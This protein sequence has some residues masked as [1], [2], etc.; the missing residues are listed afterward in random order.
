[1]KRQFLFPILAVV[2]LL[3]A[4][5][6]KAPDPTTPLT[7]DPVT[8]AITWIDNTLHITDGG[9]FSLSGTLDEG[10]IIVDADKNDVV[11]LI[12][13]GVSVKSTTSAPLV[14]ESAEQVILTLAK[15]S[16][17][18]LED[19]ADR[20][21]PDALTATKTAVIHADEDL[22]ING[23]GSL[24]IV[25]GYNNGIRSKNS[26]DIESGT[27]TVTAVNH[28]IRGTDDVT[29]KGGTL[30]ITAGKDGIK[31]DNIEETERGFIRIDGGTI[32]ITAEGDGMQAD[33]Y[34][35]INGGTLA[36]SAGK[37]G[38]K[39]TNNLTLNGGNVAVEATEEDIDAK[40]IV[41]NGGE[42]KTSD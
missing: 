30:A 36:I 6:E 3:L 14:V 24:E 39:A 11:T 37:R 23:E 21:D 22:I 19:T 18:K 7:V 35:V 31:S 8:P 1:M 13:D 16:K 2:T 41:R 5:C 9:T 32:A 40:N 42:L 28:G 12:L 20:G 29:I 10:Q 15:G 17:N 25:A 38:I 27:V 34:I 26:V 4:S 33:N